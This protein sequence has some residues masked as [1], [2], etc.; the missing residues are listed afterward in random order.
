MSGRHKIQDATGVIASAENGNFLLVA[1][2]SVPG[3]TEA[4]YATGCLFLKT[5][6]G[7]ATSLWVNEGSA[8]SANFNAIAGA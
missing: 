6:G 3:D 5:D 8:S 4:G 2:T 1:G 7:A